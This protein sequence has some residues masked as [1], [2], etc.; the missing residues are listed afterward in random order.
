MVS[1]AVLLLTIH[2]C[3]EPPKRRRDERFESGERAILVTQD[4]KTLDC[5][6]RDLSVG[7]AHLECAAGWTGVIAGRLTFFVDGATVG[8][9]TVNI[10]AKRLTVRFDQD[11][12]TRRLMTAKLFTGSYNSEIRRVSPW[13]VI[14][15]TARAMV[16]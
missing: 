4:D 5:V 3:I 6:V 16:S 14:R 1:V 2:I 13:H 9:R 15:T 10:R 8:F 12:I 11:S 7:G